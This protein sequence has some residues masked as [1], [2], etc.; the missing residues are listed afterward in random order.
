MNEIEIYKGQV[1]KSYE[2]QIED[3][4]E[5]L[6]DARIENRKAF[7]E[8]VVKWLW[9]EGEIIATHPLFRY[10]NKTKVIDDLSKRVGYSKRHLQ[11]AVKFYTRFPYENA[12]IAYEKALNDKRLKEKLGSRT[13]LT[14]RVV[15][16]YLTDG[17]DHG[18][19]LHTSK[20]EQ[21]ITIT[22]L[23]DFVVPGDEIRIIRG[24]KIFNFKVLAG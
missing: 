19:P 4:A 17:K 7:H 12:D 11:Y 3:L 15:I 20:P 22:E 21:G 6:E 14:E 10:G 23:R 8:F 24:D 18:A 2:E 16:A 13:I 5:Q 9:Q 1:E